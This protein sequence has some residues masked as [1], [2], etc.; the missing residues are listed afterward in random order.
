MEILTG[1]VL[2]TTEGLTYI[3]MSSLG[4]I[5][6]L[7]GAISVGQIIKV[8]RTG[9]QQD[10]VAIGDL[11]DGN[12][13]QWSWQASLKRLRFPT[14]FPFEANEKVHIIYKTTL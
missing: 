10:K 11:N 14:A 1:G 2:S 12:T 8:S 6:A 4:A 7:G 9:I 3:D 13:R 5:I